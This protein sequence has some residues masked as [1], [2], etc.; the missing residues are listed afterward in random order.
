MPLRPHYALCWIVTAEHCG[1]DTEDFHADDVGRFLPILAEVWARFPGRVPPTPWQG[2]EHCLLVVC[3]GCG[4]A[5]GDGEHFA[6]VEHA[7]RAADD[8]GWQGDVCPF[9]RPS[10]VSLA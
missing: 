9:C 5:V 6:D 2:D 10:S 1:G 7:W 8:D 4:R 3:R